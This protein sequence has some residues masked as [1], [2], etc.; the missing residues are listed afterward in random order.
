MQ[1]REGGENTFLAKGVLSD[2]QVVCSM[3]LDYQVGGMCMRW[4]ALSLTQ[5]LLR[6]VDA[7]I[8]AVLRSPALLCADDG[9]QP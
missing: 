2:P 4:S 1:G 3:S 5:A 7:L 8:L 9:A 6:G